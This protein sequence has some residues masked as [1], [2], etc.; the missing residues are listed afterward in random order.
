MSPI[1]EYI[2]QSF[3][4]ITNLLCRRVIEY[5]SMQYHHHLWNSF[6]KQQVPLLQSALG[7]GIDTAGLMRYC[8]FFFFLSV[9]SFFTESAPRQIHS[10]S[11]DV[12][13]MLCGVVKDV[14]LHANFS[15][16]LLL[17]TKSRKSR[18]SKN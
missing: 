6:R 11:C 16:D 8:F 14:P 9:L 1:L 5:Y 12:R 15:E 10:I 4:N 3:P 7:K 2:F 18:M 17:L 13:G